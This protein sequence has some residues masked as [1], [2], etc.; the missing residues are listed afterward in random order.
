[1]KVIIL[2][3]FGNWVVKKT[4]GDKRVIAL[5]SRKY[6]AQAIKRAMDK[7]DDSK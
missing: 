1:M 4:Q 6:D 5:C 2:E 7:K 3:H